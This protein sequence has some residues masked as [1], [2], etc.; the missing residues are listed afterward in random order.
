MA[1]RISAQA[2]PPA[3]TGHAWG[4]T[5]PAT[6]GPAATAAGLSTAPAKLA[7]TAK[8]GAKATPTKQ[9]VGTSYHPSTSPTG[10]GAA[11]GSAKG[12]PSGKDAPSGQPTGTAKPGSGAGA[13]APQCPPSDIVLSLFTS[14]SS[15]ASGERPTFSVYAVSTSAKECSLP[16][17]AGSVKVVVSRAGHVVWDSAA[18]RPPVAKPVRFT[19]AVPQVLTLTWNRKAAGPGGCAG[20]LPAGVT[21]TLQAVAMRDGKSSPKAATFKLTK[22]AASRGRRPSALPGRRRPR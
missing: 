9:K 13:G 7:A 5:P 6:P 1:A 14:K 4:Y 17:G 20:A 2:L 15:Y 10:S 18:C 19:L 12:T 16:Y 8:P 21:G 11:P 22:L 3:A